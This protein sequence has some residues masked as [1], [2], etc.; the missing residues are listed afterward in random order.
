MRRQSASG[1]R[2]APVALVPPGATYRTPRRVRPIIEADTLEQVMRRQRTHTIALVL[3]L[4]VSGG[5]AVG[6]L[7]MKKA[8]AP[9]EG[10]TAHDFGDVYIM[11][12]TALVEHTFRLRNRLEE[13]IVIDK[14]DSSCGCTVAK[15]S[16]TTINPGETID[17]VA[18]LRLT[19]SGT[20]RSDITLVLFH[21]DDLS[22][23]KLLVEGTGVKIES[24]R[25]APEQIALRAG[26]PIPLALRQETPDDATPPPPPEILAPEGITVDPGEWKLVRRAGATT[27]LWESKCIVR[28]TA[29]TLLPGAVIEVGVSGA[30]KLVPVRVGIGTTAP[31]ETIELPSPM[32][33]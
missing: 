18:T 7:A 17:L 19:R 15:P 22:T 1:G 24:L 16:S 23:Y 30:V 20:K 25:V 9:L 5:A 28:L 4:V 2:A 32:D 11:G 33:Q 8:A 3:V 31:N 27:S 14:V 10:D 12:E 13:T 6:F 21:G 29:D 26:L